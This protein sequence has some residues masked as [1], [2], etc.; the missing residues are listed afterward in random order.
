[1]NISGAKI[2]LEDLK[3]VLSVFKEKNFILKLVDWV[4]F[5]QCQKINENSRIF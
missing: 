2:G 5:T 1:M 3:K 4:T